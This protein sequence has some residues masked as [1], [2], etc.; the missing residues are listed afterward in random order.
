MDLAEFERLYALSE[1]AIRRFAYYRLPSKTDGD[2]VLQDSLLLAFRK[3]ELCK[4]ADSFKPWLLRIVANK[5]N[6]FYRKRARNA[7][8]EL[9]VEQVSVVH[10]EH[11]RFGLTVS[12]TVRETLEELG[13]QEKQVLQLFYLEQISQ[14]KIAKLLDIPVGTVKSRLHAARKHFKDAY[15]S[16]PYPKNQKGA[17]RMSKLPEII[18]EYKI[19]RL[20]AAPFEVKWEEIMGWFIVPKLGEKLSWAMYDF[21]AKTR[22]EFYDLEV[23]GRASV[24][25]AVGVEIT[26]KEHCGG[27]H[28]ATADKRD[29]TRTF[30]AQLTDTHCRILSESHYEDGVKHTYTFLDA[31]EFLPNW[32]FGEDNCGNETHLRRK[33]KIKRNGN[34]VVCA[35]DEFMLDITDRC[36]VSIG[37]LVFDT[38]RVMDIEC[39]NGGV[40][41]EQYLDSNGRTVLWRRFNRN[42]WHL[43]SYKQPWSE[44]LPNNER[45]I[46]NGEI[47]VHW[48]DC[49]TD[50]ILAK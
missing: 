6:D 4:S 38:V 47:Y 28:E 10:T 45:L 43:D 23:M 25:G 49:I 3:R 21:P 31:D 34:E 33:D 24:H 40:A 36:K 48:Y 41:T 35:N 5:C 22:S 11:S 2:D 29:L 32:G 42:D 9:S 14:A 39:Y 12:D 26:A 17:E 20:S 18:P 37:G 46:I 8:R 30:I 19:E 27:G 16:T 13:M 1:A 44:R 50:Y 7:G 15:P